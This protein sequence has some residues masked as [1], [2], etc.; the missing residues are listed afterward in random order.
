MIWVSFFKLLLTG[1]LVN[2]GFFLT[3]LLWLK[4]LPLLNISYGSVH[5]ALSGF[6]ILRI[7]MFFIWLILQMELC[8]KRFGKIHNSYCWSLLIPN[9][10][11]LGLGLYG[12]YIE[13]FHLTV[14][15]IQ[16][17]V[18]GLEQPVRIEIGRAH[19]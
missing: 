17:P 11:L 3:D 19:V 6:S 5:Q 7:G 1:C 9:L 2:L 8:S 12:F 15:R 10:F 16:I 13:P 4:L 14:S 18:S